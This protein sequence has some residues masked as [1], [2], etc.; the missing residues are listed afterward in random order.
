MAFD[1][2]LQLRL[3]PGQCRR[4]FRQCV[5]LSVVSEGVSVGNLRRILS[6]S[7][8]IFVDRSRGRDFVDNWERR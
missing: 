5:L 3:L 4:E 2:V 6:T 7:N 1:L 8:G